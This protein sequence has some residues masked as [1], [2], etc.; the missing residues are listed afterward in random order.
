MSSNSGPGQHPGNHPRRPEPYGGFSTAGWGPAG[1]GR[2]FDAP[3]ENPDTARSDAPEK[4]GKGP[5]KFFA[6]LLA[7]IT[8]AAVAVGIATMYP[9]RSASSDVSHPPSIPLTDAE[10]K[11]DCRTIFN[12]MPAQQLIAIGL[13]PTMRGANLTL[14][15]EEGLIACSGNVEYRDP[16]NA[17][18]IQ[19]VILTKPKCD[20]R[21]HKETLGTPHTEGDWRYSKVPHPDGS[22]FSFTASY[23]PIER[24]CLLLRIPAE[25]PSEDWDSS[26]L[27]PEGSPIPMTNEQFLKEA[28]GKLDENGL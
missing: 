26:L 24:G 6:G 2:D 8:V 12:S 16:E 19:L 15:G 7:V 17:L 13:T 27:N 10:G 1:D 3:A 28:T 11:F 23:L 25:D 22:G 5:K 20:D 4:R 21:F 9:F 14:E 18:I